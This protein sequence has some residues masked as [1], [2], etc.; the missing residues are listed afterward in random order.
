MSQPWAYFSPSSGNIRFEPSGFI[1]RKRDINLD[2]VLQIS[3]ATHIRDYSSV[4]Y[5]VKRNSSHL[6]PK[7]DDICSMDFWER[8]DA[9]M[10]DEVSRKS[11]T[12]DLKIAPNSFSSWAKRKTYPAADVAVGIAEKLNT[13]VEALVTGVAPPAWLPP[14]VGSIAKKLVKL[15]ETQLQAVEA[16]ADGFLMAR[17]GGAAEKER[18]ALRAGR[19][20]FAN[21]LEQSDDLEVE[22]A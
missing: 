1:D 5:F 10:T 13:T 6:L 15:D 19:N 17:G 21:E 4:C 22:K 20:F 16:L 3:F 12:F 9:L 2:P 8:M 11:I 7:I 18:D 14:R